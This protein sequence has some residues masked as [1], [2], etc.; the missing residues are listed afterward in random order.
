MGQ[1]HAAVLADGARAPLSIAE[2]HLPVQQPQRRAKVIER[3]VSRRIGVSGDTR[4][5]VWASD[6][7]T[8]SM[9]RS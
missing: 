9:Q 8:G 1:F 7:R 5:H 3:A 4:M 6:T 2:V